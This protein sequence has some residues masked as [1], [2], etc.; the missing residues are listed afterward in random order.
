VSQPIKP[1]VML[2]KSRAAS[3][4]IPQAGGIPRDINLGAVDKWEYPLKTLPRHPGGLRPCDRDQILHGAGDHR[5]A[6]DVIVDAQGGVWYSD[7]L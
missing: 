5:A 1:Q 4:T 2:D 7:W 6:L 3:Q